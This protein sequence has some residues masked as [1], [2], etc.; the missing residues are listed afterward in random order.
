MFINTYGQE[1]STYLCTR[2][3]LATLLMSKGYECKRLPS[4]FRD[5]FYIWEFESSDKLMEI[6]SN[7]FLK[8]DYKRWQAR[9]NKGGDAD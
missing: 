7:F 4:P 9:Q 3:K 2:P 8:N 5:G 1:Q 6:V